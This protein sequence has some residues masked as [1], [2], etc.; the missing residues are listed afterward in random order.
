M[1]LDKKIFIK[2]IFLYF[3]ELIQYYNLY[4]LKVIK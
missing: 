1:H 2:Y 3:Y 4:L